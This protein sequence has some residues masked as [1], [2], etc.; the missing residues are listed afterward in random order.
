MKKLILLVLLFSLVGCTA[1]QKGAGI[2]A[3]VGGGLG[4]VIGHQSGNTAE[5]ALIGAAAGGLGGALIGEQMGEKKFCPTC[6]KQ[7]GSD[8]TYC[9]YDGTELKPIKK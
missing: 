2:G 4:A 7:F 1:A 9:P 8:V 5:G 3:A 6:G